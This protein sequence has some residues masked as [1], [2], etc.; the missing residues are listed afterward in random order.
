MPDPLKSKEELIMENFSEYRL[1][2]L[3]ITETW[4]PIQMKAT[5]GFKQVNFTNMITKYLTSTENIRGEA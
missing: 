3:L 5:P 4:L 1:D 2:G